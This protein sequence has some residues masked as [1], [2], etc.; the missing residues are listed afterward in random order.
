[1]L[2]G[3]L[4]PQ[5]ALLGGL[6]CVLRFS[7]TSY[8]MESYFGG[9]VAAIGGA[10]VMGA[11]PRLRRSWSP[12][13][14][15]VFAVGLG[16]IANTRAYEGF[17]FSVPIVI[18]LLWWFGVAWKEGKVRV[19]VLV[20]GLLLFGLIAVGMAYYN[21]RSTGSPT[22]PPYMVSQRDYHMTKPF[23]WQSAYP[24]RQYRHNIMR[25][26][27]AYHEMPDYYS[28]LG[29]GWL[30]K[31]FKERFEAYYNFFVWPMFVPALFATWFM[32]KQRKLRIVSITILLL[33]AGLL[34][35]QWPP[36]AHYAAPALGVALLVVIYGLRLLRTYHL[37]GRPF[38]SVMV[39]AAVACVLAWAF[40]PW[41]NALIDPFRILDQ[42]HWQ[43]YWMPSQLERAR[44]QNQLLQTPG[45]HIIFVRFR[46]RDLGG[47]FW[48]Y[49]DPD[50]A[51]SKVIWAYDMGDAANQQLM[52]L[53][54]NRTAWIVD[55]ND[56][57]MLLSRYEPDKNPSS[58]LL[59][60]NP[61]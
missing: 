47:I 18:A 12:W 57:L 53:Y 6:Y 29:Q 50:I 17:V 19:S 35:E 54:P 28:R 38:G 26:F 3:W 44:M 27:F 39:R 15:V 16:L 55:K 9:A 58:V 42:A 25:V 46:S 33:L 56:Y 40:V 24:T 13:L 10:L 48:I 52:Q 36:E 8:W 11:L 49:N 14:G 4:P 5:W 32:L 61:W 59:Q 43:A 41:S 23:I 34:I 20:P 30:W 51:N 1:M 7:V 22:L 37:K 21:W 45:Q 60:T 2:Q 31:M